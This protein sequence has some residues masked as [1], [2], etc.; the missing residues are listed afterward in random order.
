M[1]FFI[2]A[3][4]KENRAIYVFIFSS[5]LAIYLYTTHDIKFV[6][7]TNT[8]N[9]FA[10]MTNNDT[11]D[12]IQLLFKIIIAFLIYQFIISIRQNTRRK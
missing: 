2:A 1:S 3:V 5:L 10:V 4:L 12:V 11:L 6:L 7:F 9:P 8:V